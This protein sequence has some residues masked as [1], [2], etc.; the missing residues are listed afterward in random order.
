MSDMDKTH[1]TE[2]VSIASFVSC[3]SEEE[4][5]ITDDDID[6]WTVVGRP[7]LTRRHSVNETTQTT[8]LPQ[9]KILEEI[10]RDND[11]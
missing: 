8:I 1:E 2:G 9:N 6:T 3:Q 5:N 4:L 7:V 10:N 11:K